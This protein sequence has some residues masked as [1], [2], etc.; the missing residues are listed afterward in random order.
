MHAATQTWNPAPSA[1]SKWYMRWMPSLTDLAFLLPAFFLFGRLSGTRILLG[2]GDTGWHIRTGEWILNHRAVPTE[3][4]FSFTKPHQTWFAW[5]WGWDLLFAAIHKFWGLGG[6]AFVNVI[7]LGVVAVLLYKLVVRAAQNELIGFAV[8]VVAICG[9]S[10]HWLARPHLISWIFF[11]TF[12]H[13]IQDAQAGNTK[14]LLWLPALMLLWVNLHGG[15][16]LGLVLLLSTAMGKAAEAFWIESRSLFDSYR[17]CR[18]FLLSF[19]ACVAV[20]FVNPYTWH[21]HTHIF[22]YLTDHKLLDNIQ[23]FQSTSFH[24]PAAI[25]FEVMLVLGCMAGVWLLQSGK[26]TQALYILCWIHLALFSGRNIPFFVMIAAPAIACLLQETLKRLRSARGI[27]DFAATAEEICQE[28]RP[29]EKARRVHLAS[30]TGLIL[31][32]V[33]FAS[34][35]KGF[36]AEFNPESFPTQAVSIVRSSNAR[37]ILTYD[38]WGD[39]LI[40]QLYPSKQVFMD[41]RSDFYGYDHISVGQNIIGARYDW[42]KQLSRFAVDMVIVKPDA[43]LSTVLK[44]SPEWKMLLDDGKALVFEAT[45]VTRQIGCRHVEQSWPVLV[46]SPYLSLTKGE[47]NDQFNS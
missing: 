4:F 47:I 15:F 27:G 28:I 32:A 2:D 12:L 41:G 42:E 17:A 35:Q 46:S 26:L 29:F 13:L 37:H 24:S 8:T 20:T 34:G 31:L 38:Q 19:V 40:Y 10:I 45:S 25:Y 3:D 39:Y 44:S 6:V 11:L 33:L 18:G 23:E 21:L 1:T 36:E 22:T 43:P 30:A 16:F 14:R 5:E 7:V 9:S